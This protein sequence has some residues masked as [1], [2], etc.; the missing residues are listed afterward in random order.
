MKAGRGQSSASWASDGCAFFLQFAVSF[1]NS[2]PA[3]ASCRD[4]RRLPFLREEERNREF[5]EKWEEKE[6]GKAGH[7]EAKLEPGSGIETRE[8]SEEAE[9]SKGSRPGARELRKQ[10]QESQSKK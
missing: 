5:F 8:G 7:W 1:G 10:S 2:T 4:E 9:G 3:S 6:K